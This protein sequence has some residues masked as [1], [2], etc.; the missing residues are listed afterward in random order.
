MSV[1]S[2]IDHAVEVFVHGFGFVRSRNHPYVAER[3]GPAWVMRDAVR[4]DPKRYRREEWVACGVEPAALV[5]LAAEHARSRYS[6]C[7]VR[8]E[9]ADPEPIR[10]AYKELGFRLNATEPFL[11]HQLA[12]VPPPPDQRDVAI[13][14]VTTPEQAELLRSAGGPKLPPDAFDA[15]GRMRQYAALLEDVPI[16]WVASIAVRDGQDT[17]STWCSDLY[18]APEHRRRGIGRALMTRMLRDDRDRGMRSS[19]LSASH[20]GALLYPRV[21]YEALGEFLVYTPVNR[22]QE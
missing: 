2:E 22:P 17:A 4:R 20:A 6:L 16:G 21:G 19:V 14:Q 18:V 8:P 1:L 10:Q 9:A 12:D 15:A 5:Q 11:W 13:E 7:V 3:V